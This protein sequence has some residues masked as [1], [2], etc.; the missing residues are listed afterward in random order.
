MEIGRERER[1]R[2]KVASKPRNLI[3]GFVLPD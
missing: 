1:E 3:L 2:E